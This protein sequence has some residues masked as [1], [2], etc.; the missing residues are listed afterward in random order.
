MK[1]LAILLTLLLAQLS[2]AQTLYKWVDARGNISYSDQPPPP[3]FAGKDLSDTLNTMGAATA[4][5][6]GLNFETA[7]LIKNAPIV[8]YTSKGCA[9]C[10]QGRALL[11]GKGFPF[12]EKTIAGNADLKALQTLFN[13]QSLP[14]L[15]VGK[16]VINGFGQSQWEDALTEQG[17]SEANRVPKTYVNGTAQPLAAPEKPTLAA[18]AKK[19]A[20]TDVDPSPRASPRRRAEPVAA[21]V[22]EPIIKF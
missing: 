7:G 22:P 12:S 13:A 21:P 18:T 6:E 16:T 3:N 10:D 4:Q 5:A 19:D 14:V 11:V 2:A 20:K 17:Y 1:C 15:S 8:V 9:P